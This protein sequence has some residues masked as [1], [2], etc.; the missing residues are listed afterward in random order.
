MRKVRLTSPWVAEGSNAYA[1]V[2]KA[3]GYWADAGMDVEISRG[4]GSVAAAHAVVAGRFDFRFAAASAG[5]QQAAKG[6]PAVAIASAT[7]TLA[8]SRAEVARICGVGGAVR[9]RTCAVWCDRLVRVQGPE[10]LARMTISMEAI[11]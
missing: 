10:G 11:R 6:L 4:Y 9:H 8:G 2:A 5:I 3:N 1:F 7:R